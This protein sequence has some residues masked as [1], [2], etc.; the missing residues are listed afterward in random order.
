[1]PVPHAVLFAAREGAMRCGRSARSCRWSRAPTAAMGSSCRR[2]RSLRRSRAR[3]STG[4]RL[5]LRRRTVLNGRRKVLHATSRCFM[6]APARS[7]P[8]NPATCPGLARVSIAFGHCRRALPTAR[9]SCTVSHRRYGVTP[10]ASWMP[11]S[12]GG[13]RLGSLSNLLFTERAAHASAALED[14]VHP[15]VLPQHAWRYPFV[16]V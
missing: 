16:R 12:T 11:H 7:T 10:R 13:Q 15:S 8:T 6:H 5:R 1:M 2:T 4:T 9:R 14:C 3:V